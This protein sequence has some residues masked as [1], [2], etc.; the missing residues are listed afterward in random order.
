MNH[1][2]QRQGGMTAIGIF[3]CLVVLGCFIAFGL[4][5]FPLYNEYLGVQTSMKAVLSQPAHTRQKIKHIRKLFLKNT[6]LNS[7]YYFNDTNVKEHVTLVKSK[8]GK[9]K[10]MNVKYEKSNKLFQNIYLLMKV[11]ETLEL[12]EDGEEE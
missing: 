9:K 10:Y 2:S 12:T 4:R 1:F 11:D 7:V 3:L 5:I 6:E 8:K